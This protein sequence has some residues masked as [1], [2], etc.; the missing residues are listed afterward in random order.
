TKFS[1][2]LDS[3]RQ[4]LRIAAPAALTYATVPISNAIVVAMVADY[5]LNAVA[6]FGIAM[7]LEPIALI[8]FYS[9]SAIASPFVGMNFS[10]R[11]FDRLLEARRVIARFCVIFGLVLAASLDLAAFPL[12]SLFTAS[13]SIQSV[14][15]EYLWLVSISYG[16]H[17]LIMTVNSIFN[18]L[19]TPMPAVVLT[20]LRVIFI[21]LP[22]AFLGRW[23][24]DLQGVFAASALA[25]IAVGTLAYYWI[26][27]RIR[28]LTSQTESATGDADPATSTE[29]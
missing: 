5:G 7:R 3:W 10:A 17:G 22:L 29:R 14:A 27:H 15:V 28:G 21:F 8:F 6:G 25:N 19:G 26:G 23:L 20:S 2:I 11:Q 4:I 16:A 1:V 24:F 9:L 13:D 12:T 18:G